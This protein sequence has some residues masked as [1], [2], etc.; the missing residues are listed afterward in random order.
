MLGGPIGPQHLV[1]HQSDIGRRQRL[2]R[3]PGLEEE[4]LLLESVVEVVAEVV[5]RPATLLPAVTSRL[6]KPVFHVG[7]VRRLA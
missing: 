1:R 3:H 5:V 2:H 7:A 4:G 6:R